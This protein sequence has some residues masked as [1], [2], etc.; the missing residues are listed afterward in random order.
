MTPSN[1]AGRK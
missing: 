1:S